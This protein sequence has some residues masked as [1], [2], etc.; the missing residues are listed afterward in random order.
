MNLNITKPDNLVVYQ[1]S[2]R[3]SFEHIKNWTTVHMEDVSAATT[4]SCVRISSDL[5][6]MMLMPD[7]SCPSCNDGAKEAL[8][9]AIRIRTLFS[10]VRLR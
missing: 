9:D 8:K 10:S 5:D 7:W 2:S 4:S 1:T 3:S 6:Y